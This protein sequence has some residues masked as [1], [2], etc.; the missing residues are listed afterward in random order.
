MEII[1][2]TTEEVEGSVKSSSIGYADDAVAAAKTSLLGWAFQPA[3]IRADALARIA[4]AV[5]ARSEVI[6]GSI[7]WEHAAWDE[8]MTLGQWLTL[9]FT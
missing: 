1:N 3:A 8:P 7:A 2:T 9:P 4:T 6:A 5:R